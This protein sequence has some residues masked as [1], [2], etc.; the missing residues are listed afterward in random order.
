MTGQGVDRQRKDSKGLEEQTM[1]HM[2]PLKGWKY[3][4][5]TTGKIGHSPED[6]SI[7]TFIVVEYSKMHDLKCK[8][9]SK[10]E[11]IDHVAQPYV[12]TV[13]E[14]LHSFSKH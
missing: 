11:C 4:P 13:V 10:Q 6:V 7:I 8:H 9:F 1:D 3:I 2:E 12:E 5:W 14:V